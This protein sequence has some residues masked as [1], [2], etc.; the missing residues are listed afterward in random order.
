[1]NFSLQLNFVKQD[2]KDKYAAS[3]LGSLWAFLTPL[4]NIMIFAFVFSQVM[5]AKLESFGAEFS[6][7]GYSIYLI[8]GIL[9][10]NSFSS[11]LIRVSNVF[12]EKRGILGKVGISLITLPIYVV[13]TEAVIFTISFLFFFGYLAVIGFPFTKYMLLI[14]L[15]Y[16]LQQ[17]FAYAMGFILGVFSVFMR[18]IKEIVSLLLQ[19]LFWMTP[20][21]YVVTIIPE[22]YQF[23]FEY[24]PFFWL[25]SSVRDLVISQNVPSLIP[26]IA[27]FVLSIALFLLGIFLATRLERDIRDLI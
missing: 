16:F 10:W 2:L 15:V 6:Q 18:D 9:F 5:G 4:F 23:V 17:F 1:M 27:I 7:F 11:T 21:V 20:I 8:S 25:V 12:D 22:R 19:L 24:N 3:M 26:L 14:P 13:I